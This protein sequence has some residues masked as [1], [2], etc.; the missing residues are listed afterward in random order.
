[1][2]QTTLS[3]N[4]FTLDPQLSLD[5]TLID[6]LDS[7]L[8]RAASDPLLMTQLLTLFDGFNLTQLGDSLR[9]KLTNI[10][11]GNNNS[12]RISTKMYLKDTMSIDEEGGIERGLN[13]IDKI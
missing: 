8:D 13:E 3:S 12:S 2:S 10:L 11:F 9:Q 7:F 6:T 5:F 1:M 4:L